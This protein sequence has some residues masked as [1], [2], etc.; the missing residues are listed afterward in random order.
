M[1]GENTSGQKKSKGIEESL[2]VIKDTQ[3]IL[4]LDI[5]NLKNE[6]DKLKLVSP[7]PIP[8]E[9]E[10]RIVELEKISKDVDVLKQWEKTIDEVKFL[11]SKIMEIEK[12]G[13]PKAQEMPEVQDLRKEVEDLRKKLEVPRKPPET[14]DIQEL[15]KQ[16]S[17]LKSSVLLKPGASLPETGDLKKAIEGNRRVIE[18]L[19]GKLPAKRVSAPGLEKLKALVEEHGRSIDDLKNMV[20][21]KHHREV[22][23]DAEELKKMIEENKNAM[24]ELK[25][26]ISETRPKGPGAIDVRITELID[27]V[28]SNKRSIEDLKVRVIK[29]EGKGGAGLSERMEHEIEDL[30][31]ML[32][33]KLGDLNVKTGEIRAEELKKMIIENRDAMEKLKERVYAARTRKGIEFPLPVK[34]RLGELE[35]KVNSL[36]RRV[37]N[38]GLRPIEIPKGM[39]LPTKEGPAKN[40]VNRME[41]MKKNVDDLLKR[42][43][44]SE[45]LIKNMVKKEDLTALEKA[46]KPRLPSAREKKMVSENVYKDIE[47]SKKAILR[48]EDHINNLASDIEQLKRELSTVEKR[49]WGE[50]GERP[51][52]EDILR[53]IEEIEHRLKSIGTSAPVF[54]E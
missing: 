16:I 23:T 3:N 49:E 53:R 30:R 28:E 44:D 47:N 31:E 37:E 17:D 45:N 21:T 22:I 7:S 32:Y 41:K 34:E 18:D 42:M 13:K 27:M 29:T 14:P 39:K 8:P 35:K 24:E 52:L 6:I 43:K 12:E 25:G 40:L 48:N 54:I 38:A 11:R 4:E 46:M 10:K 36:K 33:S 1:P 19:K 15:R 20:E 2:N 5:I 51:K 9:V 26:R 50:I